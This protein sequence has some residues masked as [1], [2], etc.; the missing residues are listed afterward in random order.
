MKTMKKTCSKCEVT[1]V[2]E[3]FI[4]DINGTRKITIDL[5]SSCL[6]EVQLNQA[7]V[8]QNIQNKA[9]E[10]FEREEEIDLFQMKKTILEELRHLHKKLHN[11]NLFGLKVAKV[12]SATPYEKTE[13]KVI[14]KTI[15]KKE[16]KSRFMYEA[17]KNFIKS[18]GTELTEKVKEGKIDRVF[19][20]E[21]EILQTMQILKRKRKNNPVLIGEPGV[22]KTAI[23][24][25]IAWEIVNGN[26]PN[27]LKNKKIISL[28]VN[29][30]VAGTRYRGD[31]ETKMKQLI[32]FLEREKEIIVFV[33]EI[34]NIVGAGSS[35]ESMDAA[36]ILKPYLARG[37]FYF[38][39]ATTYNEYKKFIEKD[40]ALER[41][42]APIIVKEP[43]EEETLHILK[44]I[45][46]SFENHHCVSYEEEAIKSCIDFSKRYIAERFLPDKAIDLLDDAGASF[47]L[48]SH[49]EYETLED[50]TH[51]KQELEKELQYIQEK[52]EQI[53]KFKEEHKEEAVLKDFLKEEHATLGKIK[54][55]QFAIEEEREAIKKKNKVSKEDIAKVIEKQ[56]GI[57]VSELLQKDKQKIIQLQNNL[58]QQIIGQ[59]EAIEKV[60]KTI[61]RAKAGLRNKN[62][63]IAS[64]LFVGPTGVGKTELAKTLAKE[65]F[66]SEENMLSFD[67]SEYMDKYSISKM[68]GSPPGYVGYGESGELTEKIRRNPYSLI[69]IDELEKAHPDVQ[70]LFL[71]LLEEGRLT[72]G[73]G[74]IVSFKESIVI[75]T[76]NAGYSWN[77]SHSLGF[78][79]KEIEKEP[80][81]KIQNHMKP[82][83]L[84]R[85]DHVI[86]FNALENKDLMH[87]IDIMLR[88]IQEILKEK[89]ISLLVDEEVKK[90]IVNKGYSSSFGA[91]P[92]KRKIQEMIEE[93]ISDFL[94][95]S[96][97]E[98]SHIHVKK[99]NEN[100][101]FHKTKGLSSY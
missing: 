70:H 14:K 41:R 60:A 45:Q 46:S 33:D 40:T 63:P 98:F 69:L 100:I 47:V 101:I 37:D 87:I 55:I 38:I 52:I 89:N 7:S 93:P 75:M 17:K 6:K 78:T 26:V 90:E 67:M 5:C 23:I 56:T 97:E 50:L 66:G 79:K 88:E 8:C 83:F 27:H 95:E 21:K 1:E 48:H 19:G 25:G 31:F 91:R 81:T 43:S 11:K 13:R 92:L 68:I 65:I 20:R 64:F 76:S 16:E 96:E 39:G 4:F 59:E 29:S 35:K 82:E 9:E 73:E 18:F 34:H 2:S 10:T 71:Q 61:K 53:C 28:D 44:G 54:R 94:F 15:H 85:F 51:Q 57:P 24:E 84:N 72:D 74:R 80:I 58:Q 49:K 3:Q 99:E 42:F 22:G 32:D 12:T 30:L 86:E 62:K 77:N 36:N